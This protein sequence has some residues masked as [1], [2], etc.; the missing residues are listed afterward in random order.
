MTVN[1]SADSEAK[2]SIKKG[3]N[4][5]PLLPIADLK[6][7]WKKDGKDDLHSFCHAPKGQRRKL[8]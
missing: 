5:Q 3:R 1:E 7:K 8:L 6:A 2:Q 4:S